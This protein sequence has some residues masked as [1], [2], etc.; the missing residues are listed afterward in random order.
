MRDAGDRNPRGEH[1]ETTMSTNRIAA[2]TFSALALLV[3]ENVADRLFAE[4]RFEA[5]RI[6]IVH[7]QYFQ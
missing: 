3:L 1:Y 6:K 2:L 4:A 5:E 7:Y